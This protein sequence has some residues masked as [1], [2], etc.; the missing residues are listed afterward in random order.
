MRYNGPVHG[1]VVLPG[2]SSDNSPN[3]ARQ[4]SRKSAIV[5]VL[6]NG[7]EQ[8]RLGDV[9]TAEEGPLRPLFKCGW[10]YLGGIL[11]FYVCKV[12]RTDG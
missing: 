4:N 9:W 3:I 10:S 1:S 6:V 8:F 12:L 5:A 7:F 11:R 2:A